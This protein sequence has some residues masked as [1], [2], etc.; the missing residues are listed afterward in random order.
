MLSVVIPIAL[1]LFLVSAKNIGANRGSIEYA[2]NLSEVAFYIDGE[3]TTL[4]DM[5]FYVLFQEQKVEEQARIYNPDSP[6]DYWNAHT[7]GVF[8]Q[9]EAKEAIIQM[10]IHDKIMYALA[11]EDHTVL[12]TEDKEALEKARTEFWTSLFEGQLERLPLSYEDGNRIMKEIAIM[13]AYERKLIKENSE[14][15]TAGLS[16]GGYDYNQ[17]KKNY[18]VKINNKVWDKVVVG[19]ISLYHENVNYI[20]GITDEEK[21]TLRE[22]IKN[23]RIF[24]IKKDE[25]NDEENRQE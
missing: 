1:I 9:L 20:N 19:D 4:E 10:A 12:S 16:W 24:W 6:K 2:D 13:E 15:T 17:I 8:I 18:H 5:I 21:E 14:M 23:E 7:N 3:P 22:K 11:K 25:T